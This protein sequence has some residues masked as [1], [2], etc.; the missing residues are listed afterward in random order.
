[1][2]GRDLKLQKFQTEKLQGS[3]NPNLDILQTPEKGVLFHSFKKA[4]PY[5]KAFKIT[6]VHKLSTD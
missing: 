2:C 4:Q 5:A 3:K 6:E 1:L